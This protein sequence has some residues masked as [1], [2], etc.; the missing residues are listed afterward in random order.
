[1]APDLPVVQVSWD[2]AQAF[3]RW[4][5]R[6]EGHEYCLPTEAE[7]EYACRAGSTT[8]W[9]MGDDPAALGR[10]AWF[11]GNS[12]GMPH[13][14]G[15][16][17]PNAFGLYDMHGNVWEWC[18]DEAR[19]PGAAGDHAS[20]P[21]GRTPRVLRGGAWDCPAGRVGSGHRNAA[22]A[23]FRFLVHGFRVCRRLA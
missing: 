15:L 4:L 16:T 7:W 20:G 5:G 17:Q 11:A 1:V 13:A 3:C 8:R 18:L 22:P 9:C 21:S 19:T 12:R 14:V 23:L 6:Q 10:F 2:D